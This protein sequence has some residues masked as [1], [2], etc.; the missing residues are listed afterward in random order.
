MAGSPG[1]MAGAPAD[2]ATRRRARRA[3]SAP[4]PPRA[5]PS[6]ARPS[7]TRA[8]PRSSSSCATPAASS[9]SAPSAPTPAAPT[10]CQSSEFYCPCHGATFALDGSQPTSPAHTALKHYA[11][12]VD[13]SGNVTVDPTTS[14]RDHDRATSL[15]ATASP[16][17][18]PSLVRC[19]RR[20]SRARHRARPR[21]DGAARRSCSTTTSSSATVQP[22]LIRRCSYPRLPRQRRPR[23]ARLLAG[24]AAPRRQPPTAPRAT[25][26]LSADEVERNFES[27]TGTVYAASRR[28]SAEPGRPRAA[29]RAS[30]RAPRSAA[31]STT[32]SASSPSIRP[33]ISRTT[34]STRRWPR[35]SAARSSHRPSSRLRRHVHGARGC[36][37]K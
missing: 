37:P 31:P 10:R 30:R 18:S 12:C 16:L 14:V 4:A 34:P 9:P 35:G 24:Q 36:S 11:M 1:D 13:A 26:K 15:R 3:P 28:R 29:A 23:A 32:A 6:V 17:S 27:A 7:T 2:M 19:A 22:V 33:Q 5:T 8:A 20:L 25:R 21:H